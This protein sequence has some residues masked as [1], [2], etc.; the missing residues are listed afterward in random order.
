M[1]TLLT[2]PEAAPLLRKTE[3]AARMWLRTR[4]CPIKVVR[5]GRRVY[6]R[7]E[8]VAALIEGNSTASLR[9]AG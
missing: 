5:I 4:D 3:G 1:S 9:K 7:R 2:V 8:D 6:V